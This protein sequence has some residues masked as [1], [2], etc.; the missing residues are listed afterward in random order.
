M[1]LVFDFE[2]LSTDRINAP[3]VSMALIEFDESRFTTQTAYSYT[4]LLEMS[5]MITFNV[6]SQVKDHGRKIDP[7]TLEWWGEQGAEAMA[8]LKPSEFDKPLSECIPFM[9]EH[10]T[11]INKVYTRGNTFDPVILDYIAQQF[12]Q[13][14]PYMHWE[15]RDTRS[16][17]EGMAWGTDLE[18]GFIPE[19]LEE[20]F[21]KHD[22]RH[23]V[24]MDVMR[25]QTLAIA[26]G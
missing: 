23:D 18:N 7:D 10:I 15:V 24:A 2:T 17:I 9:V 4:E 22:P 13:V 21:V 25:I 6:E 3:I 26:L 19:G 5:R 11:D 12:N 8:Q 1:Q 14:V 20:H 16:T